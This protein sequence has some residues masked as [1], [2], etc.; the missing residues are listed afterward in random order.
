MPSQEINQ[1]LQ[2]SVEGESLECLAAALARYLLLNLYRLQLRSSL[3]LLTPTSGEF[4]I[5]SDIDSCDG[6]DTD[7]SFTPL[8]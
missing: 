3:M 8:T 7:N 2:A 4:E 6:Q 1:L 5:D